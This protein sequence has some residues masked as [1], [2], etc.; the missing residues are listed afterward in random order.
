MEGKA[1]DQDKIHTV[2]AANIEAEQVSK[3][4]LLNR[5]LKNVC[6]TDLKAPL[7]CLCIVAQEIG[8]G[9]GLLISHLLL[10]FKN[11]TTSL[12]L[13]TPKQQET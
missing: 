11:M 10:S 2:P 4:T 1:R 13:K 3:K 9:L 7:G 6:F 5:G 8:S 12:M